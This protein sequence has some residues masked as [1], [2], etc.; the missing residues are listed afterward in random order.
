MTGGVDASLRAFDLHRH[1]LLWKHVSKR[2]NRILEL[3]VRGLHDAAALRVQRVGLAEGDHSSV[4]ADETAPAT[5]VCVLEDFDVLL[6][7]KYPQRL[8]NALEAEGRFDAVRVVRA[9]GPR[10]ELDLARPLAARRVNVIFTG[11]SDEGAEDPHSLFF[12]YTC[13]RRRESRGGVEI[14]RFSDGPARARRRRCDS[15]PSSGPRPRGGAAAYPL[16][17]SGSRPAPRPVPSDDPRLALRGG[18]ATSSDDSA[19]APRR[20]RGPPRDTLGRSVSARRL[21][22][23][24][25][26]VLRRTSRY[27]AAQKHKYPG[28]ANAIR[29]VARPARKVDLPGRAAD[30]TSPR[31]RRRRDPP[32]LRDGPRTTTVARRSRRS[33]PPTAS[34]RQPS[35]WRCS[36]ST[37]SRTAQ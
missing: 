12:P 25:R 10:V 32:S 16:G 35:S 19:R 20:R 27:V 34:T 24:F 21:T 29:Q 23:D 6:L 11:P 8:L 15:C 26:G 18:A 7:D 17:R 3:V 30:E 36:A 14:F 2:G 4:L 31:P 13:A 9:T 28:L 1:L 22:P 33:R 5:L 37:S